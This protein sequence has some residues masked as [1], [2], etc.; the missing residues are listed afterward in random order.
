MAHLVIS[1]VQYHHDTAINFINY[2]AI[3]LQKLAP[4]FLP[5]GKIAFIILVKVDLSLHQGILLEFK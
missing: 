4:Y 3:N 1:L 2:N 5:S